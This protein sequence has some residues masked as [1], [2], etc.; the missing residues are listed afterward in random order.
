MLFKKNYPHLC[1]PIVMIAHCCPSQLIRDAT[2]AMRRLGE[3]ITTHLR[4][5]HVNI[6]AAR[7]RT[8]VFKTAPGPV[9]LMLRRQGP[10]DNDEPGT[11]ARGQAAPLHRRVH[12]Q[13]AFIFRLGAQ[14]RCGAQCKIFGVVCFVRVYYRVQARLRY[15]LFVIFEL[16]SELIFLCHSFLS[17]IRVPRRSEI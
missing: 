1:V 11:E 10:G 14:I 17:S 15:S 13:T 12:F 3:P 8:V 2:A 9:Q 7:R 4:T 5:D 6:S 16:L